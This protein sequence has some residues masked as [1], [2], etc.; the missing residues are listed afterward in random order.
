MRQL[1]EKGD[2]MAE[3]KKLRCSLPENAVT[4]SEHQSFADW[5]VEC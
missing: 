2:A 1:M 4:E 5:P 3:V